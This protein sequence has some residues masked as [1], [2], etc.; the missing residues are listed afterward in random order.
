MIPM[1]KSASGQLTPEEIM[2][3]SLCALKSEGVKEA[4]VEKI[5]ALLSSMSNQT[6]ADDLN[7]VYSSILDL[8]ESL[9]NKISLQNSKAFSLLAKAYSGLLSYCESQQTFIEQQPSMAKGITTLAR[10]ANRLRKGT[11]SDAIKTVK[12]RICQKITEI[13]KKAL[14]ANSDNSQWLPEDENRIIDMYHYM[15]K[16]CY[17]WCKSE[18]APEWKDLTKEG[19]AAFLEKL[20]MDPDLKESLTTTASRLVGAMEGKQ[21]GGRASGGGGASKDSQAHQPGS[22]GRFQ[23]VI[24]FGD[25]LMDQGNMERRMLLGVIPMKGLA[26]LGQSR[27][28]AF[29]DDLN[30]LGKAST[31]YVLAKLIVQHDGNMTNVLDRGVIKKYVQGSDYNTLVTTDRGANQTLRIKNYAE[32]GASAAKGTNISAAIVKTLADE[33][34]EFLADT[35]TQTKLGEDKS[36]VLIFEMTGANDMVTVN[37]KITDANMDRALEARMAHVNAMYD[38]GYRHFLLGTLPD[39]SLSSEFQEQSAGVQ[40]HAYRVATRFN[41]KL[42]AAVE[43]FKEEHK[44]PEDP[45]S[46]HLYDINQPFIGSYATGQD[47]D[48]SWRQKRLN[49]TDLLDGNIQSKLGISKSE[50]NALQDTG[51]VS[52]LARLYRDSEDM[53]SEEANQTINKLANKALYHIETQLADLDKTVSDHRDKQPEGARLP[54]RGRL[55][56]QLR[57]QLLRQKRALTKVLK[58]S[59]TPEELEELGRLFNDRSQAYFYNG[60]HPSSIL[61]EDIEK[62][63]LGRIKGS[64]QKGMDKCFTCDFE[65]SDQTRTSCLTK[66]YR[67]DATANITRVGSKTP[68]LDHDL[69]KFRKILAAR[70]SQGQADKVF[71]AFMKDYTGQIASDFTSMTQDSRRSRLGSVL[72]IDGG[73][74]SDLKNIFYHALFNGG[75]RSRKV[76]QDLGY[77]SSPA[78]QVGHDMLPNERDVVV[79]AVRAAYDYALT[80][81]DHNPTVARRLRQLDGSS[82]KFRKALT[83]QELLSK[84]K[85]TAGDDVNLKKFL[86]IYAQFYLRRTNTA[87][88]RPAPSALSMLLNEQDNVTATS[89]QGHIPSLL[90]DKSFSKQDRRDFEKAVVESNLRSF[91]PSGTS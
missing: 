37:S 18:D 8:F 45:V 88:G 66:V 87:F 1:S 34:K 38:A 58:K 48:P 84:A 24:S 82:G 69:E 53:S 12:A 90:A 16:V 89:M 7:A 71:A 35:V 31:E 65:G 77:L 56:R 44:N 33:R 43:A 62:D 70:T 15:Q 64:A 3:H 17:Q 41:E 83:A 57:A 78:C 80:Q 28:G 25:S 10:G 59:Y 72:V 32:G 5:N 4:E 27:D 40:S 26:G 76:L 54:S 6:T 22:A 9:E 79:Q 11:S 75:R 21:G 13:N 74:A 36:A 51:L 19:Q 47:D 61:Y 85:S 55:K 50:Y 29:S 49:R 60:L 52:E 42:Q 14:R 73:T 68:A 67:K 2:A 63:L 30:W 46:I 23:T 81:R 39:L 20:K 86:D 91:P